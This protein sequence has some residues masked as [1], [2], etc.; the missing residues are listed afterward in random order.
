[1]NLLNIAETLCNKY[2]ISESLFVCHITLKNHIQ[3]L[4]ICFTV[5]PLFIL[6]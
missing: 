1:M 6:C 2:I 5:L 3:S 4:F